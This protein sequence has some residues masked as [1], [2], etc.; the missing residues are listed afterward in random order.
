[1]VKPEKKNK[2][3][4]EAD[5]VQEAESKYLR[6]LADYQNLVR[7]SAKEKMEFAKYANEGLLREIIPVYDHLKMSLGYVGQEENSWMEGV[8]HVVK[9]FREVL[10]SVGVKEVET[11]GKSFDPF[12]MDAIQQEITDQKE[13]DDQIVREI[14]SGYLL[15]D[16]VIIPAQV[17]VYRYNKN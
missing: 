8:R 16:K 7:Q 9:Q 17:A 10:A 13:L 6:A 4:T 2:K 15:H 5:L 1:M 11:I 3:A 12:Q 14:R